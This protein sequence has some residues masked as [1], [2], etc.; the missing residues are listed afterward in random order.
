MEWSS[1]QIFEFLDLY[2]AQ[3]V[4]W[5]PKHPL[6][7]NRNGIK[8]CWNKIQKDFSLECSV[9]VLK[10]KRDS[11]MAT[12]R[13]LLAK[14][15]KSMASGVG[16]DEVFKPTWFVYEKMAGFLKPVYQARDTTDTEVIYIIII[17]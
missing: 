11:L 13:P 17:I 3:P 6:H 1:D 10:K 14:V 12:F 15:K 16:I 5:N 7:R 2:Q 4:L 9:E 8:D